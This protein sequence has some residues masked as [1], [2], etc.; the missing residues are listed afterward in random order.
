MVLKRLVRARPAR[1][2]GSRLGA[3]S[4]LAS[5]T[6]DGFR[7]DSARAPPPGAAPFLRSLAF[8]L[9]GPDAALSMLSRSAD[10]SRS[11]SSTNRV[12][13]PPLASPPPTHSSK[14]NPGARRRR[15]SFLSRRKTPEAVLSGDGASARGYGPGT[16]HTSAHHNRTKG[17]FARRM[18]A[19]RGACLRV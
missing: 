6:R 7:A 3:S 1:K 8:H 14:V 15:R 18:R 12:S 4:I 2:L 17:A 19:I 11:S 5:S 13:R 9:R 10:V 16:R